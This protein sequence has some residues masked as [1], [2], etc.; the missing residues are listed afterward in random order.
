[1]PGRRPSRFTLPNILTILRFVLIPFFVVSA[2]RGAFAAALVFFLGAAITDALDGWI[3]RRFDLRSRLG[4][5]LD[6]AADK[7]MM[8]FG[9]AV[10]T[11]ESV[12]PHRLPFWLTVT[13]FARDVIIVIC[14]YL[15]YR[16]TQIKRFPPSIA[17]KVSTITQVVALAATIGANTMIAPIA[18]PVM[19]AAQPAAFVM[20]LLSGFLY[21]RKWERILRK[22]PLEGL[23]KLP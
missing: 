17:G 15:I 12:A 20:T 11:M 4:A 9:Y 5:L 18:F 22:A 2:L 13:V 16:R 8:V 19:L 10:F 6:P 23:S 1:M 7:T 14:A 21:M 3:A